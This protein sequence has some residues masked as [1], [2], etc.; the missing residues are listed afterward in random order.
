MNL[1]ITQNSQ[2]LS[3]VH[4]IGSHTH[5]LGG[6]TGSISPSFIGTEVR[7]QAGAYKPSQAGI[8]GDF[9]SQGNS[10]GQNFMTNASWNETYILNYSYQPSGTVQNHSHTLP[11]NTGGCTAFN[12]GST[13]DTESRPIDFTYK[14]W[15]RTA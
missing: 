3:H 15:K 9:F 8:S 2:N 1:L 10:V 6:S 4:K 13:G 11:D 12:S 5:T 7:G 14:V